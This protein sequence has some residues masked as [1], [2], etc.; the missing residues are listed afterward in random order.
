MT[1]VSAIQQ[2]S[3]LVM[4]Q[5]MKYKA[6]VYILTGLLCVILGSQNSQTVP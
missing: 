4:E 6:H 1:A 3:I 2:V 5:E